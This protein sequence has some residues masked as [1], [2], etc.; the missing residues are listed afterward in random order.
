MSAT[1]TTSQ[2]GGLC[3]KGKYCSRVIDGG[4]QDCP[5]GTYNPNLGAGACIYCPAGNLCE[6]A[7]LEAPTE[8]PIGYYCPG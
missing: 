4:P 6:T 1:P 5:I 3:D 8:C 2:Q 7:G